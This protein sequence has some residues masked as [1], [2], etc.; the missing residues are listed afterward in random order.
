MPF[1]AHR[2]NAD[3]ELVVPE[4]VVDGE[5]IRCP[6]CNGQ[7]RPRGGGG[8]QARHFMHVDN[9]GESDGGGCDGL[10]QA[11]ESE[12]HRL[13]KSLA[14][15]GLRTRFE[16]FGVAHCG[17]E[18]EVDVTDG[19]SL[20][21]ERYADALLQ[22]EGPI[23]Q[24]NLFFGAGVVVEVQYRNESK[25]VAAVTADY[26]KAG[27]SVYW[28]YEADFTDSQFCIDRFNRAF[29]ERWPNAFA[30]YFIDGE[31]ALH[32]VESVKFD[33]REMAQRDWSFIDPRP[34]CDH[35]LHTGHMGTPFCLDCGTE[36][37]RHDTGR[38]MYLPLGASSRR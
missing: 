30:P 20:V 32:T 35:S 23:T 21:T 15:S 8:Q 1:L 27:Y 25:D 24:R 36:L 13:L 16:D 22:F 28:A 38:Q 31:E 9:L 10:G 34:D 2:D 7:M 29:N 12:Q 4:E 5:T 17:L 3:N 19:P 33:P 14:V 26:L 37:G 6:A 18:Y 11:G